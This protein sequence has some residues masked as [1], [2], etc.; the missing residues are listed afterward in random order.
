MEPVILFAVYASLGYFGG[1]TA[2]AYFGASL[3]NQGRLREAA[4]CFRLASKLSPTASERLLMHANLVSALNL[5]G[6]FGAANAEWAKISSKLG[7]AGPY[8]ALVAASYVSTLFCQGRY[9]EGVNLASQHRC[10]PGSQHW[11]Q[12]GEATRLLNQGMCYLSMGQLSSAE[13]NVQ[14]LLG[15]PVHETVREQRELLR[16]RLAWRRGNLAEAC[17]HLRGLDMANLA[18]VYVEDTTLNKALLLALCGQSCQAEELL[19]ARMEVSSVRGFLLRPL[20]EGVLAES[21][22]ANRDALTHYRQALRS[23]YPA[24]E[25]ALRA[26]RIWE[27]HGNHKEANSYYCEALR[28]DPESF[29]AAIARKALE[30]RQANSGPTN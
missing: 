5:L 4:A 22:G 29:W 30:R 28:S 9:S 25:A 26:A 2:A 7:L 23:S 8:R 17:G 11:Q 24:G 15:I 16:A 18:P 12:L 21:R 13:E 1:L 14:S 6:D 20:A 3:M 10:Y 19:D 27:R